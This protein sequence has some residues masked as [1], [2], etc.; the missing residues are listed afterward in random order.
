MKSPNYCIITVVECQWKSLPKNLELCRQLKTYV[1]DKLTNTL[2]YFGGFNTGNYAGALAY[3][4]NYS[5]LRN[6][7]QAF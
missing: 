5:T 6:F 2:I 4:E 3:F 7:E 1:E